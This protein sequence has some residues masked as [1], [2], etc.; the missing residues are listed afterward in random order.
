M[1]HLQLCSLDNYILWTTIFS[2]QLYL[3]TTNSCN[4]CPSKCSALIMD[5]LYYKLKN[6]C[7]VSR[8]P[9]VC[10]P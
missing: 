7:G 10:H 3:R 4:I 1:F 5:V 2:G 8:A 9:S 6:V